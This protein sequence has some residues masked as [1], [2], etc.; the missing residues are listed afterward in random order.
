VIAFHVPL[1]NATQK[2]TR[3]R[4]SVVYNF[5]KKGVGSLVCLPLGSTAST[6]LWVALCWGFLF[7]LGVIRAEPTCRRRFKIHTRREMTPLMKRVLE[8]HVDAS[9]GALSAVCKCCCDQ[10]IFF[11]NLPTAAALFFRPSPTALLSWRAHCRL[12]VAQSLRLASA[13]PVWLP[14]AYTYEYFY[15][16]LESPETTRWPS[17]WIQ[18][19]FFS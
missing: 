10:T 13:T 9:K 7:T 2:T 19:T 6:T 4:N 16:D 17:T 5:A 12:H 14:A 8:Q 15:F 3:R 1:H 11:C 18:W